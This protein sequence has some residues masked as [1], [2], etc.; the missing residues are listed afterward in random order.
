MIIELGED[1]TEDEGDN[2]ENGDDDVVGVA[3]DTLEFFIDV[4]VLV[5]DLALT[6][7]S[8]ALRFWNHT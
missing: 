2:D 4:V 3:V 1:D 5:I 8:L 6:D 7:F